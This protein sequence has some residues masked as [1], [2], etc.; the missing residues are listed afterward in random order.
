[1][2]LQ[3]LRIRNLKFQRSVDQKLRNLQ[4]SL[5][6]RRSFS[7][8]PFSA[9][10]SVNSGAP[11]TLPRFIFSGFGPQNQPGL[12]RFTGSVLSFPTHYSHHI[13][14]QFRAIPRLFRSPGRF[15]CLSSLWFLTF[16][17]FNPRDLYYAQAIEL[18]Q[19]KCRRTTAIAGDPL[20]TIHLFQRLSIAIHSKYNL[21]YEH[22]EIWARA[23]SHRIIV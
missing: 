1:M 4:Q 18:T 10:R 6:I 20:E 8:A 19:E 17:S 7:F 12:T 13:T 16:L 5:Q 2:I 3:A 23:I 9:H 11:W 22:V 15:R 21:F 14:F